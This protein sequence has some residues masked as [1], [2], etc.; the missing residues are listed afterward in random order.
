ML[1]GYALRFA[2]DLRRSPLRLND[3]ATNSSKIDFYQSVGLFYLQ[4]SLYVT[5]K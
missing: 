1:R 3:I 2:G 4:V 5:L